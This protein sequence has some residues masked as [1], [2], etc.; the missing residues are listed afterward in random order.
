MGDC[1]T[2][3]A[4]KTIGL[5]SEGRGFNIPF[6]T[7]VENSIHEGITI[8]RPLKDVILKEVAFYNH[9]LNLFV[10]PLF[11]THATKASILK[12]TEHF[13]IGLD[14]SFPSTVSTVCRTASKLQPNPIYKE[15]NGCEFCGNFI[16]PG[17]MEWRK[18]ITVYT[19]TN[20]TDNSSVKEEDATPETEFN[21][22]LCYGCQTNFLEIKS[23]PNNSKLDLL[24]P[25]IT[26]QSTRE[27]MKEQIK[28]YFL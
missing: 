7:C 11:Q 15:L 19:N 10:P 25:F 27:S 18:G 4:I 22:N 26:K 5:T 24:P 21:K 13:L 1:S 3:I 12:L 6:E 2:R 14:R 8:L 28:D 17:V 16:E 9:Y 23:N 20:S